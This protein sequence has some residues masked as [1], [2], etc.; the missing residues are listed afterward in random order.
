[1]RLTPDMIRSFFLEGRGK[2]EGREG[3]GEKEEELA[4]KSPLT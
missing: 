1:M 4:P 2:E 3:D